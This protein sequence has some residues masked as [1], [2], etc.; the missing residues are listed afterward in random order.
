ML[1][2]IFADL[3][4][5]ELTGVAFKDQNLKKKVIAHLSS[6]GGEAGT[7]KGANRK[8]DKRKA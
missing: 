1:S 8:K 4:K 5:A 3:N 6:R 2:S 7:T